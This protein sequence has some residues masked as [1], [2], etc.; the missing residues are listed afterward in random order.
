MNHKARN[1]DLI[2]Q[3]IIRVKEKYPDMGTF[4]SLDYNTK[5]DLI[6]HIVDIHEESIREAG[7]LEVDIA[8][9]F[10]GRLAIKKGK[11]IY[12]KIVDAYL[13][14]N[15]LSSKNELKDS[16]RD[17]IITQI[18]KEMLINKLENSQIATETRVFTF[19]R[20]VINTT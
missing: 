14:E 1:K 6:S 18:R 3:T 10:I 5:F 9:P 19:K 8:L 17:N 20:K 12:D 11:V 4:L 7:R 13:K 2:D 16:D 15:G